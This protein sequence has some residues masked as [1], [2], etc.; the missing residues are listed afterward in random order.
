MEDRRRSS[1]SEGFRT[2]PRG[3]GSS[4]HTTCRLG[5]PSR[6]RSVDSRPPGNEN[7]RSAL[8]AVLAPA[9]RRILVDPRHPA[10]GRVLE[11][12]ARRLERAV[13]RPA[14]PVVPQEIS[15]H[16]EDRDDH[17]KEA[18]EGDP[19]QLETGSITAAVPYATTSVIVWPSSDE[20]NR[21][22]TT[23]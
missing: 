14:V 6:S 3:P 4:G 7:L 2:P 9:C 8:V 11:H 10:G 23:A 19:H 17:E 1:R 12:L 20:S 18:L 15:D 21:I 22:I 5:R 13:A 16:R